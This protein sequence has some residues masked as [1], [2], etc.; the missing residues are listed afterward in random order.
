MKCYISAG[1]AEKCVE[2][3]CNYNSMYVVDRNGDLMVNYR[4]TFTFIADN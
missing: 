2:D 1:Y 4:K 3:G